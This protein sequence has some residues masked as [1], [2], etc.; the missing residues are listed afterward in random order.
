MRY[1][2]LGW[3]M[4]G[5]WVGAWPLT[6]HADY[7]SSAQDAIR[8]GDLRSAQIDL[9][10]AIRADPHN[11]EAHYWLSRVV[12]EL[13]DPVASER[14]AMAARDRGYDPHRTVPLLA[15]ALLAQNKF[16]Q[17]LDT[18][19]PD[20][21]DPLLD[22]SILV[23]RGNALLGLKRPDDA[24]L[25]FAK[26][27]QD[28]PNAVEP[29]LADARL[30][31]ARAD[32]ATAGT[33][34]D[35]A[36]AAQ[37]K[38]AEA[39]LAK[40][41]LLRLK[42]DI[43]SAI[44]VLDALITDQPSIMQ[45]RLDRAS[46]ELASGNQDAAKND[47]DT[48][49]KATP[50][51]VQAIYLQAV[52]QAQ[53]RNYKAA[54][55]NLERIS[56]FLGQIQR[57]YYLQAVVKEQL[58][59]SEQAE[60][61]A[62]KYLGRSPD[63][64]AAYKMLA[65]IQFVRHRPD[66]VIDT[67]GKAADSGKA[68]A[69]SYDLL[70]R[71][72]AAIGRGQ[73]AIQSFQK[74][75]ALAPNDVGLQTRL[76][77]V[78]MGMGD[79]DAA[80]GD[81]EHTLVLA[82]KLPAV[83]EALFFAALATG[84][85]AKAA[86]AL[87]RIRAAEGQTDVVGNLEGLYKLSQIDLAGAQ[88]TFADVVRK[89]PDFTPAKINLARVTLMLGDRPQA[90]TMLSEV[91][92]RRPTTE[93][94]LTMLASM[95]QQDNR[96]PDAVALLERAHRSDPALVRVTTS[97]GELYIRAND[98]QKAMDLTLAAKQPVVVATDML[99]LRAAAYLALGQKKEARNA[100][101]EILTQDGHA[102]GVRRQLVALLIEA[103]D[104]E[105]ARN[106]VTAGL[107][108]DPR[109]YQLYRDF[110]MIDLKAS[111]IDAALAT[112]DRL[113]AQ[114]QDFSAIRALRG[115]VYMAAN[116]PA[117]AVTAYIEANNTAPS[118]QLVILAAGAMLRA[119]RTDDA[120]KLLLDWLGKHPNDLVVTE[121]ISEISIAAG[122]LDDAANYLQALLKQ[123]PHDA[124]ALNNLAWV[125]QQ[126]GDDARAQPLARQAYVLSPGPQTADTLGWI[127]T[128]SGNAGNGVALLRQAGAETTSDP[129]ILFHYA[130]ALK[131]TGNR[132]EARKQLQTVIATKG[133]FKEKTEAR[134]LL[135][136]LAKGS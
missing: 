47:I 72:F 136:D 46:L 131:D 23:S 88:A 12:F 68:D 67:L 115:D 3:I 31:V 60:E 89:Y 96:M 83:G 117:D 58:G 64:L 103:G 122:K 33:K 69:E 134:K 18:L 92:A 73:E 71:A 107:A 35:Q 49:L 50:G 105:G 86:D 101:A 39:L 78:R 14:E 6:A 130:V 57:A 118:A 65:R 9:R 124:V 1:R 56:A 48:V 25:A 8:K 66:Q 74:A 26:A 40:A 77:A 114:D 119:G 43:P 63:D 5:A 110:V 112:A 132:Q 15:Q 87:A 24:Q 128:T 113:E 4:I 85:T 123:K 52:T 53:A 10:N 62:L 99:S 93:P 7:L 91:L 28:A 16:E 104:F 19:K 45:A 51:N 100:D 102:V 34:I 41:Q 30:A 97:L 129:R 98:P 20:G 54:D 27:E 94:A 38:S 61:A 109:N 29:L 84:D 120:R 82:P 121:Q 2:S 55:A 135:D 21:K 37:P 90:E 108:V 80:M 76:A 17:L 11:A 81:L 59:Q 125:Y 116:R 106:V 32:L 22:A 95:Y 70:G 36:I 13:G 44:T 127:L 126:M 133:D 79:A 111:G 75:E 42:N